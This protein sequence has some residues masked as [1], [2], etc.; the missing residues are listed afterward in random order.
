MNVIIELPV[1]IQPSIIWCL[2]KRLDSAEWVAA[3]TM[4]NGSATSESQYNPCEI[5]VEIHD[6]FNARTLDQR[7]AVDKLSR[8]LIHFGASGARINLENR[9]QIVVEDKQILAAVTG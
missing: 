8:L 5:W 2:T 9:Q 7:L 4:V 1:A 6:V 3:A